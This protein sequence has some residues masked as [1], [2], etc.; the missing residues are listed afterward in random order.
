MAEKFPISEFFCK[1][2][3]KYLHKV[4]QTA[5]TCVIM[6]TVDT[7]LEW[8]EQIHS[9]NFIMKYIMERKKA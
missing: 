6:P 8:V 7:M 2:F 9:K 3:K 4:L 5:K 1:K